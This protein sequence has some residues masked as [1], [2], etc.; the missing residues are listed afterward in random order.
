MD[1]LGPRP[2][3]IDRTGGGAS[4]IVERSLGSSAIG[5]VISIV[6]KPAVERPTLAAGAS[7]GTEDTRFVFVF[8]SGGYRKIVGS[9]SAETFGTDGF[10]AVAPGDRG[11][12]DTAAG[13]SRWVVNPY[14]EW[15]R[16]DR[17]RVFAAASFYNEVRRN[18]TPQ[19]NNDTR[20]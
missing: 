15:K 16:D 5:G 19:Q 2:G 7:Y 1:L 4:R 10:V 20:L 9:V 3:R 17:F 14:L 13:V 6:T 8:G 11:P 12:G 18:G